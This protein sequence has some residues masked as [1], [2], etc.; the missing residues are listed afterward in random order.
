MS[1]ANPRRLLGAF[2]RTHR[3]HLPTP[4][5][6]IGRRR[7]P[8]WRREELADAAG[9]SVTWL[10]WLEQGRE[11]QASVTTLT[12][13]AQALCLS[14]AERASLFD[15][16][17]RRDPDRTAELPMDLL[18]QL[19]EL[20]GQFNGPAYLIDRA[21]TAR[22]W[23]RQAAELFVDWLGVDSSE[24]NLL[25]YVFLNANAQ[26]FIVDWPDRAQRL[27]AEFRADYHRRPLD[28]DLQRLVEQL[29]TQ[30][31]AFA[32]YW[33]QQTVLN[34]EGGERCFNH[35][36]RGILTYR[37]TTLIVAMQPECK[38]VCLL[39]ND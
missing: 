18:P 17:G 8:G 37:Q 2:I 19:L 16:A 1:D 15:L 28:G 12:R 20:P 39:A 36:Q 24:R 7:T 29:L 14:P 35:A 6:S 4:A 5:K 22:A 10:T 26:Q 38:L 31:P 33:Q 3:E 13:L 27:V 9:V 25:N 23:N 11:V 32:Q 30:S 21:W 34:R